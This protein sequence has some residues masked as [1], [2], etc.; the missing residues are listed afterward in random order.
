MKKWWL[1]SV[2]LLLLACG[3]EPHPVKASFYYW[4]TNFSLNET[5]QQTLDSLKVEKLYIRYFDVALKGNMAVPVMPVLF[6]KEVPK[7]EIVPVV[8]IK[9]EVVLNPK[10]NLND[11]ADKILDY[12]HQINKK[13]NIAIKEIQLDCDWSL[14]SKDRFFSLINFIRQKE[15]VLLSSTI[16]LHQVKYHQ[17]TG[18]PNVDRGVLMYYN[19]GIIASDSLNSI[20][21][22]AIAHKYTASLSHYPLH[23]DVALPVYS[24]I[25]HSRQ[26]KIIRLISRVRRQ[27]IEREKAFRK[28]DNT[29]FE[30]TVSGN[31][32]G[33]YFKKED[34]IKL[35]NVS[36]KDLQEMISDLKEHLAEPPN[37]I[38]FYDL[39]A[40]N[41]NAY[42][43]DEF[44][45]LVSS[46]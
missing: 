20:Y 29:R 43:K 39:D 36:A 23:L 2:F 33:Q 24:W 34:Q 25:V 18:V 3:K 11:L 31:Y 30:V 19:M 42:E 32:F 14:N 1:I 13:N 46:F 5:E 6:E 35:E 10:V 37:E 8:Y 4:K 40:S 12:T 16:R 38:I 21:D 26:N 44:K 27:D 41:I 17:K 7:Q 15:D 9:N 45:K 22:R 28:I